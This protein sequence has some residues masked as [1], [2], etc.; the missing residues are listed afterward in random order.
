MND[1]EFKKMD[2]AWMDKMAP[3]RE[4]TISEGML[5]GF[6]TSVERRIAEP[7]VPVRKAPALGAFVPAFAV[8]LIASAVILRS[9]VYPTYITGTGVSVQLAQLPAVLEL[10]D[11]FDVLHELHTRCFVFL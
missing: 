7:N 3:L 4:K 1:K 5:K 9:P 6:A 8:I 11:E 10:Q 2:E